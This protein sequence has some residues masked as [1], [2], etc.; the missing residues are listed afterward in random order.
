M[1]VITLPDNPSPNG[2]TPILRDFSGVMTPFLGGP[3]QIIVRPGTRFGARVALPPLRTDELGRI[4]VSRLMQGRHKGILMK[5]PL[6][7]FDPGVPGAPLIALAVANGTTIQMK[8]LTAGYKLKEG[9][10]FSVIAGGRRYLHMVTT[11]VIVDHFGLA[12]VNIFP[13]LRKALLLNDVVEIAQPMIEGFISPGQELSWEI[14]SDK[15][16]AISFTIME[17]A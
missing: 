8:G 16:M 4:Y 5:W 9:Q 7:E 13:A 11:D 10:F 6:L 12:T 1:T 2:M 15:H 14:A 17:R 3:E